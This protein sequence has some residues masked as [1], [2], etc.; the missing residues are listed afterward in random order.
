MKKALQFFCFIAALFTA[1]CSSTKITSSWSE[2]DKKVIIN[3]LNK[4]LVV[5]LFKNETDSR[6]AED[7]MA[8]YLKG[9][10]V[11]SYNYFKS[12]FDK[13]NEEAIQ[14]KI[15]ADGFDGAI[16]MRLVDMEQEKIYTPRDISSFPS[17]YYGF[18]GYYHR[19]YHYYSNPAYY[20]TT[21]IYTVEV[22]VYSIRE[23]K[24][25]WTGLTE[26]TDPDGVKKMTEEIAKVVYQKMRR[27]GFVNA[28]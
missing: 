10:G 12:K 21:K 2:P 17:Y 19:S 13:S 8:G 3:N 15:K 1:S 7:Q 11:V 22:L 27:E 14:K 5:A 4:V 9:K 18:S 20:T 25:I 24:I 26:T 6:K 28:K 16:T 23:D